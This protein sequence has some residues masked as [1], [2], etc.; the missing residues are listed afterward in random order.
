MSQSPDAS[1]PDWAIKQASAALQGGMS[2]PDVE[3]RLIAV[4]LT[5]HAAKDVMLRARSQSSDP[6]PMLDWA[7]EHVRASLRAGVSVPEI[8]RRLVSRGLTPEIAEAVTTRVLG[9]RARGELPD[10]PEQER[11]PN[12][13][14]QERR[15]MLHWILSGVMACACVA[16]GYWFGGGRSAIIAFVWIFFPLSFVW[17]SDNPYFGSKFSQKGPA[18]A[19]TIRWSGWFLLTIYFL[20]RVALVMFK[21]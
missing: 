11:S 8:E 15:R 19:L 7:M 10:S 13:P 20:Y 16:M 5:P 6:P 12:S 3:H 2:A 14:E 4:G 18:S 21:A 1:P 9:E 17:F